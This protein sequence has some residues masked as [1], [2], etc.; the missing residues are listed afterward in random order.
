MLMRPIARVPSRRRTSAARTLRRVIAPLLALAAGAAV[1]FPIPMP[2]EPELQEPAPT[3]AIVQAGVS[4]EQA[5]ELA[6]RRYP[7]RVVRTETTARN[8]RR[9]HEI[10]I[11]VE[12]E[13]EPRM[14]IVRI[15]AENGRF[16]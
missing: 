16:L 13:G 12:G 8:G 5:I 6:L 15:D 7:G 2:D 11:Y 14:R 10:R 1:A 4:L 9:V 3:A